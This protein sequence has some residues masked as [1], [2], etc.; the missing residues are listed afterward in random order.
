MQQM[1]TDV[2]M[3]DTLSEQLEDMMKGYGKPGFKMD[4][5]L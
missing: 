1:V 4:P 5:S 3:A 2:D